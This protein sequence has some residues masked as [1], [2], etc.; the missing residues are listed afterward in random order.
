[1]PGM[2][3]GSLLPHGSD[4]GFLVGGRKYVSGNLANASVTRVVGDGIDPLFSEHLSWRWEDASR[5][6]VVDLVRFGAGAAAIAYEE[7]SRLIDVVVF[8]GVGKVH[9]DF[10]IEGVFPLP[11]LGRSP[12]VHLAVDSTGQLLAGAVGGDDFVVICRIPSR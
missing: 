11:F 6:R 3:I 12:R 8:D 4:G 10:G 5:A 9:S 7:P 2:E 1:M